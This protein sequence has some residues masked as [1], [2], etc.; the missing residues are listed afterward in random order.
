M[1]S[2][3]RVLAL[4]IE[5]S[6]NSTPPATERPTV[7]PM[8]AI[9]YQASRAGDGLRIDDGELVAEHRGVIL[10]RSGP[11]NDDLPGLLDAYAP[12]ALFP[13]L[14]FSHSS[15]E[16]RLIRIDIND[17]LT[18]P[19][20]SAGSVSVGPLRAPWQARQVIAPRSMREATDRRLWPVARPPRPAMVWAF[21]VPSQ[22]CPDPVLRRR[23]ALAI[24]TLLLDIASGRPALLPLSLRLSP[25]F[26]AA[27]PPPGPADV[28][29]YQDLPDRDD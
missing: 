3:P 10:A 16:P 15:T 27:E 18:G 20:E 4:S 8:D 5:G 24:E 7:G 22:V 23:I 19:G 29:L 13:S 26:S 11:V 21:N 17:A 2:G 1:S 6:V 25:R 9:P 28:V 12:V 14:S